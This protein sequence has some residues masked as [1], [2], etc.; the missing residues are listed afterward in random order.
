MSSNARGIDHIGITVPNI[1]A[2]TGS[3]TRPSMQL[4]STTQ[5]SMDIRADALKS[6]PLRLL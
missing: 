6:L 5:W 4:S 2:A 3:F 1:E